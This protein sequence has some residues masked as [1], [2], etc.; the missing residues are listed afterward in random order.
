M[1]KI[2][3]ISDFRN[4]L[5]QFTPAEQAALALAD[6]ITFLNGTVDDA[7]WAEA[8]RHFDEGQLIELIGVIGA[9]NGFNRMANAL[10]VE[11]TT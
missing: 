6:V 9:F 4:H 8:A 2:E 5:D 3:A 10:R 11:V 1:A 7:T